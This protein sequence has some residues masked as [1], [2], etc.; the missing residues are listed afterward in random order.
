MS[1]VKP[2]VKFFLLPLQLAVYPV[3]FLYSNNIG[4]SLFSSAVKLTLLFAGFALLVYLLIL[5][6]GRFRPI[7][8]A[9]ASAVFLL[10]FLTYGLVFRGMRR[11]DIIQIEHYSLIPVFLF[12]GCYLAWLAHR[13]K[14]KISIQLW[15]GV[16]FVISS[17]LVFNL[18]A[19]AYISTRQPGE[20]KPAASPMRALA[21]DQSLA[22]TH[23]DIYYI[24]FDEMAGF[25]P[26]RQYW[27]Y[28]GANDFI[29]YL[30]SKGFYVAKQSHS[31]SISTINQVASRLN[32]AVFPYDE[33]LRSQQ[34]PLEQKAVAKNRS[35]QYLKSL[36][37]TTVVFTEIPMAYLGMPS[38]NA[39]FLY[40][41]PNVAV[42]VS[43]KQAI[44]DDFMI[45]VLD[46]T[47]LAPFLG[48]TDL[49]SETVRKH[50]DMIF[51]TLEAAPSANVPSPKFVFIHLLIP[52]NPFMFDQYGRLLESKD[53]H[54][55]DK[56]LGQYIYSLKLARELLDEIMNAA[57]PARPPVIIFQS[58]HGARNLGNLGDNFLQNYPDKYKTWIVNTLFL[59]GC[60]DA[61]LTQDM[62]PINTFPIIFNCYF[63]ANIPLQ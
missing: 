48:K 31:S 29:K 30:Q 54:N 26:M 40:E 45:L 37:Y 19:I 34:I 2:L 5:L 16:T 43:D 17:L 27:H 20:K 42:T 61:P 10:F 63:D 8:A 58:D 28:D 53:Y 41:Y 1:K 59:P 18:T 33:D 22:Q 21:T 4:V 14:E 9:N 24:I 7:Q 6:F 11:I 50:R 62:D 56:Y 13:L 49:E 47:G 25:E 38:M 60:Q 36:G 52:H 32:Y 39:D 44:L 35:M 46:S 51:Y 23:P 3:A 15:K 57:D 55:W 12:M